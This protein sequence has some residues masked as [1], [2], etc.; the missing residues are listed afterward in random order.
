[1]E[2]EPEVPTLN[3]DRLH[4]SQ[5]T[6]PW[7]PFAASQPNTT[8]L[9]RIPVQIRRKYG[10]NFD[11]AQ[12]IIF[13]APVLFAVTVPFAN[14]DLGL[15]N[16]KVYAQLFTLRNAG[17]WKLKSGRTKQ[18]GLLREERMDELLSWP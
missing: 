16:K 8:K 3:V 5:L 15:I 7:D 18:I 2:D 17:L 13:W 1:M 14:S 12:S 10:F 4:H 11:D 9:L 6:E